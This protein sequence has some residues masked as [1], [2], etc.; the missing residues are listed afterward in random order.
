MVFRFVVYEQC[1]HAVRKCNCA[2]ACA[3]DHRCV[4]MC[5]GVYFVP[6]QRTYV[7]ATH[8]I[9]FCELTWE[10]FCHV[11]SPSSADTC[12]VYVPEYVRACPMCLSAM[13]LLHCEGIACVVVFCVCVHVH[14][15]L[16][17]LFLLLSLVYYI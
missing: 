2:R 16:V 15:A 3:H 5:R 1:A 13:R 7:F 14:G 8:V 9:C 4:R 10:T 12:G 6:L 17:H 11:L